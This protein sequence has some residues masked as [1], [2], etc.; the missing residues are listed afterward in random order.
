MV[1]KMASAS[2]VPM[3]FALQAVLNHGRSIAG[4][5]SK[6][7]MPASEVSACGSASKDVPA[8]PELADNRVLDARPARVRLP[9]GVATGFGRAACGL[10][11]P[12]ASVG[13]ACSCSPSGAGKASIAA[14]L[15]RRRRLTSGMVSPSAVAPAVAAAFLFLRAVVACFWHIRCT[16]LGSGGVA[17]VLPQPLPPLPPLPPQLAL[18]LLPLLPLPPSPARLPSPA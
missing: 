11:S 9:A 6:G 7:P 4:F 14:C 10:A 13:S 5:S 12:P 18:L 8:R 2:R 16:P 3:R 15:K 17:A 1:C